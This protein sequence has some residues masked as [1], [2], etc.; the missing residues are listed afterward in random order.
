MSLELLFS[1]TIK[2]RTFLSRH[3]EAKYFRYKSGKILQFMPNGE[4][5]PMMEFPNNTNYF[6]FRDFDVHG[7]IGEHV[8]HIEYGE[9]Y[10]YD[11]N[12]NI[13]K[14]YKT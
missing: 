7:E 4:S 3:P 6:E 2:D 13:L 12:N 14:V 1:D 11:H 10:F 9:I 5:V 8:T